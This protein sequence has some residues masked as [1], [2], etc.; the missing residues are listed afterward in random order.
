M[1]V[2]FII[3]FAGGTI[4]IFLVRACVKIDKSLENKFLEMIEKERARTC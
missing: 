4:D 3:L 1:K 2:L